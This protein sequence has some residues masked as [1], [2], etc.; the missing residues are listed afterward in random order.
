MV[1][2]CNGDSFVA[3]VEL[4]DDILPEYPGALPFNASNEVRKKSK[5]WIDKTYDNAH[6]WSTIRQHNNNLIRLHEKNRAWPNKLSSLLGISVINSAQGGSSMDRI[7]RTSISDLIVLKK[8]HERIVAVIGITEPSRAEL[9]S[10]QYLWHD[11]ILHLNYDS[12]ILL[13]SLVKYKICHETSYHH[14]VN[15]LKNVILIKDF[16]KVNDIELIWLTPIGDPILKVEPNKQDYHDLLEYSDFKPSI[17]MYDIAE[18]CGLADVI[19]PSCHWA[20]SIHALV[21][22]KLSHLIKVS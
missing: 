9:A 13:H 6:P 19:L 7:A 8:K 18:D 14:M 11:V 22:Q 20:E 3:G 17:K 15:F 10:E 12:D 5:Q 16:C 2:Y 4:G 21:A 1:V